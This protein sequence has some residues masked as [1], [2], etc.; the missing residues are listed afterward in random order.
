[1]DKLSIQILKIKYGYF[2][3]LIIWSVLFSATSAAG[4]VA[5]SEDLLMVI[6]ERKIT[7]G[8]FIRSYNKNRP[9]TGKQSVDEYLL[10][11][12]DFQLKIAD[13]I[14]EGIHLSTSFRNELSEYRRKLATPY[15]SDPLMEENMA[16]E[17]YE[18]LQYNVNASHILVK[19]APGHSP[20]DTLAAWDKAMQ[21]RDRI[22][23]G[24]PFESV[25]RAT[26]D[27]PS[28]KINFGNLGYFTVFQMVY[29]FENAVYNSSPEEISM[30][31]RSRFGY[32]II[33]V[34]DIKKSRGE[35]QTAH[36][37]IGFN[38]FSES[39]AKKRVEKIHSELL[40]GADFEKMVR[41]HSTDF[42]TVD[43]GGL[44]PWFGS[45]KLVPEFE[46]AAFALDMPGDISPP[47]RTAYGWHLIKL[48]GRREIPGYNELREELLVRVR[49][50]GDERALIIRDAFV[51]RLKREWDY[52]E[53]PATLR[54]FQHLIDNSIFDGNWRIPAG[55][56]L[57]QVMFSM[58]GSRATQRD[59]AE[60]IAE[61]AYKRKPWPLQEYILN[62]YD[63][64]VKQWIVEHEYNNLEKKY[65]EFGFMMKEYRDGILL[66]EITER[67]V[68]SRAASDI[69]GITEFFNKNSNN[70]MWGKRISAT[71]YSTSDKS[72]AGK[73]ERRAVRSSRFSGRDDK[74]I[75]AP[76]AGE[77]KDSLITIETGIFSRGDNQLA[78][79][80]RWV[81]CISETVRAGDMYQLLM[82]NKVI[83][84]EPMTLDQA[85]TDV[86]ADYQ[87]HLEKEW[88][89]D[90]HGRYNVVIYRDVLSEVN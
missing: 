1:M 81:K 72:L 56:E 20:E 68:W 40:S 36:I 9:L 27:D 74:W 60:F 67:N 14:E 38:S 79:R 45:G 69:N 44:L 76:M 78:D 65:P 62:L 49:E 41:E 86:I 19:L 55:T 42:N 26:S 11:Y 13:A 88:L 59:F 58:A 90:L 10:L 18:R 23:E 57:N 80:F 71:I 87:D 77:F 53:N 64:F 50:S 47:V 30:P 25:A 28:A 48:T 54:L 37:M 3:L 22:V 83:P 70:Y 33:R 8:E 46:N 2:I 31:V 43:N 16:R 63:I 66:Y 6:N 51:E 39:E 4:N 24:E 35:I 5:N 85:V 89:K 32:H 15:L 73:I 17:A 52:T 84:P 82:I 75:I 12:T 29:P 7:L 21:I 61:N 34:N